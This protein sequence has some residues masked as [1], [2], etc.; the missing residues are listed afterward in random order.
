MED[1]DQII[2]DLKAE[3]YDTSKH[4]QGM[5]SLLVEVAKILNVSEENIDAETLIKAAKAAMA[6]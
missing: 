2:R 3:I 1:K 5:N 4:M 6:K